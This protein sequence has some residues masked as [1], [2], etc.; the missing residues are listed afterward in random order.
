MASAL[1]RVLLARQPAPGLLA[2]SD[3][4]GRYGGSAYRALLQRHG[5]LCSQSCGGEC[6]DN[7]QA[8][9]RLK[10]LSACGHA[11]KPKNSNSATGPPLPI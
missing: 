6:L 3:R 10:G 9:N 8:E 1:H 2:H 11:L 5:C 7:A 4:G